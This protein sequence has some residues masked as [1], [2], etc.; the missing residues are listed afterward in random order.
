MVL[1]RDHKASWAREGCATPVPSGEIPR[2]KEGAC[3]RVNGFDCEYQDPPPLPPRARSSGTCIG[4][5]AL[6]IPPTTTP[7]GGLFRIWKC[8][9]LFPKVVDVIQVKGGSSRGALEVPLGRA[10]PNASRRGARR[11]RNHTHRGAQRRCSREGVKWSSVTQRH[12]P[13]SGEFRKNGN[14]RI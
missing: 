4:L 12:V 1:R 9:S 8:S 13:M 3:I 11:R 14:M 6:R 5:W 7:E 10:A 2:S